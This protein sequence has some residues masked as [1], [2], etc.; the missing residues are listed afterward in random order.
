[1]THAEL[2][3]LLNDLVQRKRII[4]AEAD[5]LLA[6]YDA[7]EPIDIPAAP[8]PDNDDWLAAL[9]L[10]LLLVLGSPRRKLTAAASQRARRLLRGN[11]DNAMRRLADQVSSGAIS[12]PA[13]QRAMQGNLSGYVRQ[14][15]TAGKGQ[16]PS[17]PFRRRLDA[18]LAE[19]WPYLDRF[20]VEQMARAL[21]GR[22]M[23]LAAIASRSRSYG[24]TAWGAFFEAQGEDAEAGMVEQWISR[25]DRR[26][27]RVCAPRHL[28]YFLPAQGPFPGWD[29]LGLCRCLRVPMYAPDIYAQLT[30]QAQP[31]RRAA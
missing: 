18:R 15:A 6:D 19:Q 8:E 23:S 3:T 9:A 29:C 17:A 21:G 30:G 26:V 27:C 31:Q 12:V 24:A 13:W 20:A 4:R 25:D 10:L 16:L 7:G 11:F 5:A 1:M 28:Q 14:M 2:V 22:P